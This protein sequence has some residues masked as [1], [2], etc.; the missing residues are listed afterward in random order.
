M[1]DERKQHEL[2][3]KSHVRGIL[4]KEFFSSEQEELERKRREM[5]AILDQQVEEKRRQKE[6]ER[7]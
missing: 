2:E 7:Y 1:F 6:K 5:K 3:N 4:S